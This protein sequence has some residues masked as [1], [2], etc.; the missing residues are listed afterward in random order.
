MKSIY[1]LGIILVFL[2]IYKLNNY[3]DMEHN[4]C[5][6]VMFIGNDASVN[7]AQYDNVFI[8]GVQVV[9]TIKTIDDETDSKVIFLIDNG[10]TVTEYKGYDRRVV[11]KNALDYYINPVDRYLSEVTYDSEGD[12]DVI[13]FSVQTVRL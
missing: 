7:L 1:I 13:T 6:K 2:I 4:E 9:N 11:D 5:R 8:P 12:I 10:V 3:F